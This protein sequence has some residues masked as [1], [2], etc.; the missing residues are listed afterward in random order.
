M[1]WKP[2]G[3]LAKQRVSEKIARPPEVAVRVP[4]LVSF[5][6][7]SVPLVSLVLSTTGHQ[8][9]DGAPAEEGSS[10]SGSLA[11]LAMLHCFYW[12]EYT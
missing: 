10:R 6:S 5:S 2:F 3:Y 11:L 12:E 8:V 7:T 1:V 9:A 4:W